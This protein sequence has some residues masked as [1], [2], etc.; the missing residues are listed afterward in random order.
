MDAS[1]AALRTALPAAVAGGRLDEAEAMTTVLCR[2]AEAAVRS[3]SSQEVHDALGDIGRLRRLAEKASSEWSGLAVLATLVAML[4]ATS[5][6]LQA[7][8]A[9]ARPLPWPGAEEARQKRRAIGTARKQLLQELA[10]GP[11]RPK[12]LVEA[13]GLN[14]S[15]ATTALG[16]L[17]EEGVLRKRTGTPHDRRAVVYELA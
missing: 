1:F 5:D 6:V 10:D 17:A 9:A 3:Q 8:L 15:Q 4:E 12:E 16:E 11:K 14:R 7:E 2:R 13:T